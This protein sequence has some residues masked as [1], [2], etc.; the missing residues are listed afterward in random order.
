MKNRRH[1]K[2][3]TRKN[4]CPPNGGNGASAS[5]RLHLDL[6]QNRRVLQRIYSDAQ[7]I[8]F[9]SFLIG[10]EREAQ[11][12]YLDGMT[13]IRGIEEYVLKPLMRHIPQGL[14]EIRHLIMEEIPVS[15]VKL[16]GT[17]DEC[18]EEI[19]LGNPVLLVD[20]SNQAVMLKLSQWEK[21]PIEEPKT[22]PSIRGSQ[23]GFSESLQ[24]NTTLIRRKIRSTKLKVTRLVLGRYTQTR[25][26]VIYIDGI[27]DPGLVAEVQK[28][29]RGVEIDGVLESGYLEEMIEDAPWSPFPQ[30]KSTER[31]DVIVGNLLEGQVAIL[32]DGTKDA[33]V[34]P[35]TLTSLLQATDDYFYRSLY[36]SSI[37]LLRYSS[38]FLAL[39][40]PG[41][42]VALLNFHQEMIPP[43]LLISMASAHEEVPFPTLIETLL[44]QLAFELLR[45]AGLRL[46]R[47]VGSAVTIV[48]ALVVGQA[49]VSAGFV[50]AP[51]VIVIALTGIASF[52]APHY[53]LEWAIRILR[54]VMILLGG[55]MGMLGIMFGLIAIAIHLC[56]LRSFGVPYLSP[57]APIQAGDW[58]DTWYRNHWWKMDTRPHLTGKRNR[59]RQP[60]GQ[61]PHPPRKGDE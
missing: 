37:R 42:Y 27:A 1:R 8:V 13:D 6:A 32:V 55:G 56:G 40:L 11:L 53:S 23:E 7:D 12:I 52:T 51:V 9:R 16:I 50:S 43:G 3:R 60:M 17:F 34:V 49:A 33:L 14:E 24:T 29:L 45:E 28:R 39:V 36:S 2:G 10:G 38:L 54:I 48:G 35:T 25:I 15:S 46:P 61:R 44:M 41:V 47:Q 22:E 59:R 30:I 57:I 18:T 19:S 5:R 20:G 4:G 58:K 26:H 31:A 21:R